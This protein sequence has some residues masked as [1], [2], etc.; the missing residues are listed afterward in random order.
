MKE[1]ADKINGLHPS[2]FVDECI[3]EASKWNKHLDKIVGGLAF[4]LALASTG[5]PHPRSYGSISLVFVALVWFKSTHIFPESIKKLRNKKG[6]SDLEFVIL[7]GIEAH[8]FSL[9][10]TVSEA[11]VYWVGLM[12]LGFVAIGLDKTII[13]WLTS[14]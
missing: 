9:R 10:K 4:T 8:V 6:K 5:T 7:K 3:K 11:P 12:A 14:Q 13:N 2:K 1:N